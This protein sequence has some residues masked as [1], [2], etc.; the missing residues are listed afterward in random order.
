[1]VGGRQE[2]EC[3]V[4][5]ERHQRLQGV[6]V[7]VAMTFADCLVLLSLQ[8][9]T[10]SSRLSP[11]TKL[12]K[13]DTFADFSALSPFCF[14]LMPCI[15]PALLLL[16][17]GLVALV[18]S[19]CG[20]DIRDGDELEVDCG[21]SCGGWCWRA[22]N[23]AYSD[24]SNWHGGVPTAGATVKYRDNAASTISLQT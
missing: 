5:G 16:L 11:N 21:G 19:S 23:G 14:L 3:W 8:L 4:G 9:G 20:N 6:C 10:S 12:K 7:V 1:M 2:E 18:D 15:T 22:G 17:C 13:Q 24:G